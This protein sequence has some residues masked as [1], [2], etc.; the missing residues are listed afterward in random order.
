MTRISPLALLPRW[1][2]GQLDPSRVSVNNRD[3]GRLCARRGL[4]SLAGDA[5]ANE[6]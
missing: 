6:R 1:P 2:G 3:Q 5:L 4:G